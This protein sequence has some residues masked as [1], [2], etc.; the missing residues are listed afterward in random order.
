MVAD[1][2]R[3][4]RTGR[5]RGQL[6]LIGAVAIALLIFGL[7]IVLNAVL[8]TSTVSPQAASDGTV[9]AEMYRD[10]VDRDVSGLMRSLGNGSDY[11]NEDAFRSNLTA[12]EERLSES[13]ATSEPGTISIG[14]VPSRS[15][16]GAQIQQNSSDQLNSATGAQNWT[17]ADRVTSLESFNLTIN[18]LPQM[19][20]G[21]SREFQ[22][23][24]EELNDTDVWRLDVYYANSASQVTFETFNGTET[25]VCT[26]SATSRNNITLDI[27]LPAGTVDGQPS[28]SFTFAQGI[29]GDYTLR[30]ERTGP[31]GSAVTDGTY[32][33]VIAGSVPTGNYYNG[34]T[35]PS[36]DNVVFG[37]TV[38][39]T[40][41]AVS[42]AY[43][44]TIS[45]IS[46]RPPVATPNAAPTATFTVNNTE[47]AAGQAVVFNAS[48][49]SDS[50]GSITV[51][52]WDFDGDGSYE[53]TTTSPTT[54]YTF[55]AVG[56][57]AP[58]LRVTD[59][60][61]TSGLDAKEV[62]P[63]GAV[64]MMGEPMA[65]TAGGTTYQYVSSG[66]SVSWFS[67][68]GGSDTGFE[69]NGAFGS[70]AEDSPF[71]T[72]RYYT[73]PADPTLEMDVEDGTYEVTLQFA[74]LASGFDSDDE[75]EFDVFVEGTR[76][77]DDLDIY[78]EAGFKTEYTVT[79][80]GTVSDGTLDIRFENEIN[81]AAL[82]GIIVESTN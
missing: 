7:A 73:S 65:Y 24:V 63:Y 49:S 48:N 21:K 79:T 71:E 58:E 12:Y 74:E 75:R 55:N 16:T 15:T 43:Q 33:G 36:F 66:S 9:N 19:T 46:A 6:L 45:N 47:P 11:V 68:T 22:I 20:P 61:G 3:R 13:A 10:S 25:T 72:F 56:D 14:Y 23:I 62:D 60:D 67:E 50:D 77:K 4:V 38:E 5:S 76:V 53:T 17:V 28:C 30:F 78:E 18:K 1:R 2:F 35:D 70:S 64:N 52:Q 8:Y 31:G 69:D 34:T 82:N 32:N 40:Y 42:V 54:S 41:R 26:F 59:D 81:N 29:S 51:Y 57:F 44:T 27:D 39:M 37:A 80:T